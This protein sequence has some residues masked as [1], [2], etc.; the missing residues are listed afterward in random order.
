[1]GGAKHEY[2]CRKVLSPINLFQIDEE[3]AKLLQLKAQLGGDHGQK[4]ILKCPKVNKQFYSDIRLNIMILHIC[5]DPPPQ[6]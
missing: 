3:V 2:S 6:I 5:A 4:F 1:M